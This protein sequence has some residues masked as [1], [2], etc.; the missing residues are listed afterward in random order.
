MTW[1]PQ[2]LADR[3][4]GQDLAEKTKVFLGMEEGKFPVSLEHTSI[5][6]HH[7]LPSHIA[8]QCLTSRIE[9]QDQKKEGKMKLLLD[10][11]KMLQTCNNFAVM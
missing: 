7:S 5:H 8:L 4:D 1:S 6:I 3:I 2:D 9:D 10:I 11:L